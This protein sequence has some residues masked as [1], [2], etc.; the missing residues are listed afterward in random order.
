MLAYPNYT[1]VLTHPQRLITN[2]RHREDKH[3]GRVHTRQHRA[4]GL[5]FPRGLRRTG[6]A[7]QGLLHPREGN[8]GGSCGGREHGRQKG[9]T[10]TLAY[11]TI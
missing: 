11:D 7:H 6:P 4:G 3:V 9:K 8:H 5:P 1:R 10:Q 2:C